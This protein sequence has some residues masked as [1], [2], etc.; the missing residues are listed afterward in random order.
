M[1]IKIEKK[2]MKCLLTCKHVITQNDIDNEITINLYYGQKDN[3]ILRRIK[4]EKNIRFMKTFKVD[5]T[6][7]EIIENDNISK[8]KYLIANLNYEYGYE[9]YKDKYFYLAG[10]PKDFHGERC[11]SVGKIISI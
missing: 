5:V 10:Y 7:I 11:I 9:I 1:R 3:E 8:D 4:L 6:L 2:E